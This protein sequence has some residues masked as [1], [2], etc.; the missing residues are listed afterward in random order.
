MI[1]I[2]DIAD[3]WVVTCQNYTGYSVPQFSYTCVAKEHPGNIPSTGMMGDEIV[4]TWKVWW[5]TET[6]KKTEYRH[7]THKEGSYHLQTVI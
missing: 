3:K 1:Q 6:I 2:S 4:Q 5:K 7:R